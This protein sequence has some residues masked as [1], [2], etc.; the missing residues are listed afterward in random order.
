[1]D[2]GVTQALGALFLHPSFLGTALCTAARLGGE[3][4]CRLCSRQ[5]TDYCRKT[6]QGAFHSL[7]HVQS[8]SF[9]PSFH[10]SSKE[11]EAFAQLISGERSAL[12][13]V[14][15]MEGNRQSLLET[16]L[17]TASQE[18]RACAARGGGKLPP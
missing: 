2:S 4:G 15:Y 18:I 9:V 6:L 11:Q 7:I 5:E 1:M 3:C 13:N 14:L 17:I 10:M 12:P 8:I 16:A